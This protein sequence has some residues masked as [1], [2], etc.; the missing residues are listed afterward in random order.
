VAL[1]D[2]TVDNGCPWVV[3]A[4][5]RQGTL[6]HTYIEPLGFEC[7][8]R[9]EQ[10]VA[11]PIGSGGIVVFSSLTPHLTGPNATS[12]VRKAYILQ[13]APT[14]AVILQGDAGRGPPTATLPAD[15][16]DRRRSSAIER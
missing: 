6:A 8:S 15:A 14:G 1:T 10:A 4:G 13:Y 9:P 2:A 5:H 11:A 3:P 16:P 7:F 12:D